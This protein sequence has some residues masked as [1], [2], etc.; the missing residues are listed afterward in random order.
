MRVV[1]LSV[2]VLSWCTGTFAVPEI[3]CAR[4]R[5]QLRCEMQDYIDE[6]LEM[7]AEDYEDD[8]LEGDEYGDV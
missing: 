2:I 5:I 7:S 1:F 6:L 8:R 3:V 4:A